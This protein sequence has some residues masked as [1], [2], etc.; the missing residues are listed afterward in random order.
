MYTAIFVLWKLLRHQEFFMKHIFFALLLFTVGCT[1][2]YVDFFPYHDNG[3]PKPTVVLLPMTYSTGEGAQSEVAD[4]LTKYIKQSLKRSG[5]VFSSDDEAKI[6]PATDM[7]FYEN[8]PKAFMQFPPGQCVVMTELVFYKT[9]PYR[10]LHKGSAEV[11][12]K[13]A[14][15]LSV[16]VR[17]KVVKVEATTIQILREELVRKNSMLVAEAFEEDS[18]AFNE[19]IKA[20]GKVAEDIARTI[21]R[22]SRIKAVA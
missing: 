21:E 9:T 22:A 16:G 14:V 20:Q 12:T 11:P 3:E 7:L 4:A 10:Q 19:V 2:E 5:R 18:K 8:D 17:L 1:P 13:D 15:I 6:Y